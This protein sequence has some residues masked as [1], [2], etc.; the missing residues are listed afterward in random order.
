M[1]APLPRLT[2]TAKQRD[3][4]PSLPR[5]STACELPLS[6]APVFLELFHSLRLHCYPSAL[7]PHPKRNAQPIDPPIHRSETSFPF[8]C[9]RWCFW[10]L[11]DCLHSASSPAFPLPVPFLSTALT[12]SDGWYFRDRWKS[13]TQSTTHPPLYRTA[14]F[15]YCPAST[16]PLFIANLKRRFFNSFS[17]LKLVLLLI[18]IHPR[19]L[20]FFLHFFFP[21]LNFFQI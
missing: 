13:Q 7:Y 1:P 8:S 4:I 5:N 21:I 20:L 15:F 17:W 10:E 16:H 3:P 18:S 11:A 14:A 12:L 19:Y 6:T 2:A 9:K